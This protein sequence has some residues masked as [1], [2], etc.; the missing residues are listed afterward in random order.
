MKMHVAFLYFTSLFGLNSF[1]CSKNLS[2]NIQNLVR[3]MR[4]SVITFDSVA[5]LQQFGKASDGQD[6]AYKRPKYIF[7]KFAK[8]H[9]NDQS[10]IVFEK[11][12]RYINQRP[13]GHNAHLSE[14]L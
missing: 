10:V 4:I 14:Q 12:K 5:K 11:F 9:V 2:V 7:L 6:L 1:V 8:I 13:M 3:Q